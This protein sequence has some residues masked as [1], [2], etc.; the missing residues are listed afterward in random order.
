MKLL[1]GAGTL[2]GTLGII[3]MLGM[4]PTPAY[5]NLF[6]IDNFTDDFPDMPLVGL[7]DFSLT[8]GTS[9]V[10]V[11]MGLSEVIDNIRE[12]QLEILVAMDPAEAMI[13]VDEGFITGQFLQESGDGVESEVYFQYDG[14]AVQANGRSLGLNLMESDDLRI[15]YTRADFEV[16]V[17]ATLIDSGG[18]SAS[19][20]GILVAGT[21]TPQILDFLLTDFAGVNLADIDEI[22]FNFTT[23]TD[24]TD[25]TVNAIHITMERIIIGGSPMPADTT[26]LLLAGAELNA[27]WILPAIAAIGIGAF[28]VS[29]KRK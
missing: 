15:E 22:N 13:T 20:V 14:E 19:L 12:C 10:Q 28:V 2:A 23:T 25:W 11:Q 21:N 29:R 8:S 7:C 17:T 5:A 18:N 27:I 3:M 4:F 9:S 24:A 16:D 6:L 1:L 26:A